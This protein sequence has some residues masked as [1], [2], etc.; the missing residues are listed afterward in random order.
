MNSTIFKSHLLVL[1]AT[2]LIAA[3]FIISEKLSGIIHPMSLTLLRFLGA[4]LVLLPF[5][6]SRVE[7]RK[8]IPATLPRAAV[9][10]LFFSIFFIC[11][12]EALE[13]TTSLN[14]GTLHTLV[15]FTTAILCLF[16]FR[17]KIS[18]IKLA[19]YL[20]GAVGTVWVIFNGQIDLLLSFSINRGDYIFL[21]GALAMCFYS[22]SMKALYRNDRMI[23]MVFCI[24]V[25]GSV[26][27]AIAL[28]LM[29]QPLQWELLERDSYFQV[30]Y[31]VI[32]ATL[33]TVYLYQKSTVVLGPSRVMAYIYLNPALIAILLI[34]VDQTRIPATVI[35]GILISAVSTLI[36][37]R[38]SN[39]NV[40]AD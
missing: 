21:G 11:L 7:W 39:N 19:A 24:L 31:L 9:I 30:A 20:F 12:F 6:L 4:A 8:S 2:L 34:L 10:S 3:S 29:G 17:E 18:T 36:L 5:V 28:A 13:T 26:W 35:P 25:S 38:D 32:F 33:T 1:L 37:Q 15:P 27:M 22:I 23:T 14:T 16:L 40:V